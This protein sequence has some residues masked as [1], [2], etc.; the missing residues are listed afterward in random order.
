MFRRNDDNLTDREQLSELSRPWRTEAQLA[1]LSESPRA[2]GEAFSFAVI[3]DAEPGRFWIFRALFNIPGVF[4]RQIAAVQSQSVDFS[5]QLGDM[6][7]CGVES[8]YAGFLRLLGAL[9]ILKPYLTVIGNHDRSRPNG[10]SDSKL[11]RGLIGRSNYFFDRGGVRF[12]VVD[13]SYRRLTTAQ[14]KWLRRALDT[15][16]RK[17]VFTHVPPALLKLWGGQA[18]SKLGGF[19]Q[20]AAA[21]TDLMAEKGVERVYMGHVHCFG[22]QDYKGVRYVLTGGGGSPLFPCGASDRFHHYLTVSVG[23]EGLAERVHMLDGSSFAIPRGK[24]LMAPHAFEASPRRG[25]LGRLLARLR[26]VPEMAPA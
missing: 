14:L 9:R 1:R 12:V 6:V 21:F 7:S 10:R 5:I 22:V 4:A 17:L 24:V 20:G 26:G 19:R 13:S 16:L 2:R 8:Q 23:P 11:Y 3:G 18:V 25:R 15:P